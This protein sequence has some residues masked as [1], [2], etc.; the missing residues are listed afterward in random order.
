MVCVFFG[1]DLVCFFFWGGGWVWFC[2]FCLFLGLVLVFSHS[3]LGPDLPENAGD[4]K[5][6]QDRACALGITE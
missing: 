1:G 2:F 3:V 6:L 4:R 5:K